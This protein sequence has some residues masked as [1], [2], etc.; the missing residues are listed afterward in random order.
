MATADKKEKK[1]VHLEP[2]PN[3]ENLTGGETSSLDE[4][5]RSTFTDKPKR[6]SKP[7]G[8]SHEPGATPGS[9]F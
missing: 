6:R 7:L 9:E 3:K 8:T 5:S 4:L 2:E 1:T